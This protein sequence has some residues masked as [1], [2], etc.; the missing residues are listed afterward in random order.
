VHCSKKEHLNPNICHKILVLLTGLLLNGGHGGGQARLQ[1]LA[2]SF[3]APSNLGLL[4]FLLP[5]SAFLELGLGKPFICFPPQGPQLD[6]LQY[7]K[8]EDQVQLGDLADLGQ[9]DLQYVQLV[10]VIRD[11]QWP[12]SLQFCA[13]E[14]QLG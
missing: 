12:H 6:H 10:L 7:L 1:L 4:P 8:P 14:R 3:P 13:E 2:P 9:K 5:P 11:K